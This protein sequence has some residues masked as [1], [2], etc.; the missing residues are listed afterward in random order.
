[1]EVTTGLV[2]AG[3]YQRRRRV[4]FLDFMNRVI[5][6]DPGQELHVIL[7]HPS[8]HKPKDDRWLARHPNVHFH[9]TPTHA[10][11]LDQVGVWFSILSR[12]ALQGQSF[13]SPRPVPLA[14]DRF[15]E[16]YN[17]TAHPFEW[18]KAAV[19]QMTPRNV[20]LIDAGRYQSE[21]NYEP[22]ALW[23]GWL[24]NDFL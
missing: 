4:D 22:S 20:T 2:Q 9:V 5:A 13:T 23:R 3:H 7:D 1:M 24:S 14:I 18:T 15:I 19:H 16:A 17:Q 11:W 21:I 8:T 6:A 10:S 12:R